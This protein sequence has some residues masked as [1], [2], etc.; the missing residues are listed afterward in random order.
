[1]AFDQAITLLIVHKIKAILTTAG[2]FRGGKIFLDRG[3]NKL[4]RH[5]NRPNRAGSQN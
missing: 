4:R 1:M 2:I 3:F 5:P